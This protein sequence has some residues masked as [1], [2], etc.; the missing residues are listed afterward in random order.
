MF[1]KKFNLYCVYL[2]FPFQII[3]GLLTYFGVLRYGIAVEDNPLLERLMYLITPLYALLFVKLLS[4]YLL[5]K[6]AKIINELPSI[7]KLISTF[8]YLT[9]L[10]F[11]FGSII[12]WT[13]LLL[14][15]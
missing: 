15:G 14:I 8:I 9:V 2:L 13:Y 11:I 10:I 3:D 7:S 12:P 1:S 5:I 6:V 4:I